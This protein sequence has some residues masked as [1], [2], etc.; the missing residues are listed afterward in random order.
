MVTGA[1]VG[2]GLRRL[3]VMILGVGLLYFHILAVVV[4]VGAM[5]V[6]VV[7]VV[8]VVE[9]GGRAGDFLNQWKWA[10]EAAGFGAKNSSLATARHNPNCGR[11]RWSK[12]LGTAVCI[13]HETAPLF[14]MR[15]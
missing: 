4:V 5:W 15:S 2:R 11:I 9:A 13:N 6:V 3:Q 1:G 7:V 14:T 12:N 10:T 8:V